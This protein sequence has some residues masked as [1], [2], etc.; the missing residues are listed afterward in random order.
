MFEKGLTQRRK[1]RGGKKRKG[2]GDRRRNFL[3]SFEK[4]GVFLGNLAI[5]F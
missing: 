5:L 3:L 4:D 1:G 2:R